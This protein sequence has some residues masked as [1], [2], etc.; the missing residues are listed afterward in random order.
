MSEETATTGTA[1][2]LESL[3][4]AAKESIKGHPGL[5]EHLLDARLALVVANGEP[6][7]DIDPERAYERIVQA[8][9]EIRTL[10]VR[11]AN[12]AFAQDRVIE[13]LASPL[14]DVSSILHRMAD[15]ILRAYPAL[16][17]KLLGRAPQPRTWTTPRMWPERS[18]EQT[19][20]WTARARRASEILDWLGVEMLSDSPAPTGRDVMCLIRDLEVVGMRLKEEGGYDFHGDSFIHL[21]FWFSSDALPGY[22]DDPIQWWY[23]GG[24]PEEIRA[25][26]TALAGCVLAAELEEASTEGSRP[27]EDKGTE[28]LT[29]ALQKEVQHL[30][31]RFAWAL[32]RRVALTGPLRTPLNVI[33]FILDWLKE[34]Q[35][36]VRAEV[37]SAAGA[38]CLKSST[39]RVG[40]RGHFDAD[41]ARDVEAFLQDKA[42]RSGLE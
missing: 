40:Y 1:A 14:D 36:P 21:R 6:T 7:A 25:R 24:P 23:D 26:K 18:D 34:R 35:S 31:R 17:E 28:V 15:D 33:C 2:E 39:E 30:R 11:E 9:S 19:M 5:A 8:L 16:L 42:W 3:V 41:L 10:R 38:L 12:E 29:A 22:N 27:R 4:V 13:L 20:D 32:E 37:R